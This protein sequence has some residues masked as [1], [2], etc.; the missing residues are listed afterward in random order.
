MNYYNYQIINF[1]RGLIYLIITFVF[2]DFLHSLIKP[3]DVIVKEEKPIVNLMKVHKSDSIQGGIDNTGLKSK[4]NENVIESESDNHNIMTD[5]DCKERI[6]LKSR[7]HVQFPRRKSNIMR[8]PSRKKKICLFFIFVL[9][10][11]LIELKSIAMLAALTSGFFI[12]VFIFCINSYCLNCKLILSIENFLNNKNL[13]GIG[14]YISETSQMKISLNN[15]KIYEELSK[16]NKG[17]HEQTHLKDDDDDNNDFTYD[18]S[19]IDNLNSV[20]MN[21]NRKVFYER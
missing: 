7:T 18:E 13:C 3:A 6:Y 8:D 2:S 15:F 5:I 21:L 11:C 9:I 17:T 20:S 12:R 1:P 16:I 14:F 10:L 19:R 4:E